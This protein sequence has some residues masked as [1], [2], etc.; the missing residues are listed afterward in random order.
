MEGPLYLEYISL[1]PEWSTDHRRRLVMVDDEDTGYSI[2]FGSKNGW[3]RLDFTF[4]GVNV[5]DVLENLD[6]DIDNL[7]NP[8]GTL[9]ISGAD[10]FVAFDGE[11]FFL[12]SSLPDQTNHT[13][14]E[15]LQT[16]GTKAYWYKLTAKD[17]LPGQT[18]QQ[19]KFLRT[20]GSRVKWSVVP[21]DLPPQGG[22]RGKILS[23]NGSSPSWSTIQDV[24]GLPEKNGH[25]GEFL[26][27]NEDEG[28]LLWESPLPD[29][30]TTEVRHLANDGNTTYWS[31]DIV[32]ATPSERATL[33]TDGGGNVK[34]SRYDIL[35][36]Q[37]Y[38][39]GNV[40][41]T[42]GVYPY[43]TDVQI[44]QTL[45]GLED[46]N[47]ELEPQNN[48][49]LRFNE[50]TSLWESTEFT[51]NYVKTDG[52]STPTQDN[53]WVIGDNENRF[54]KIYSVCFIGTASQTRMADL[55]ENYTCKDEPEIGRVMLISE[56]EDFDCEQSNETAS[57]RVLGVLSDSPGYLMNK[58]LEGISVGLKGRLPCY[59]KGPVKKGEP[60]VSHTYGRAIGVRSLDLDIP[61]GSIIGRSNQTIHT[62]ETKLIEVII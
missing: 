5:D 2:Y 44:E 37:E 59:V 25:G 57:D 26:K 8:D 49:I 21:S 13:N 31:P 4:S 10:V 39:D 17:I 35:P 47:D 46:V 40:L 23:T 52:D 61:N 28:S 53:Q 38:N 1:L 54:K 55:A 24:F 16:D 33:I 22:N 41:A 58:D 34:W 6:F 45:I 32:P 12:T 3:R 14:G 11:N 48:D 51:G 62:H 9:N 36:K 27:V 42:N 30:T 60:L 19:G 20:D 15:V 56:N 43:W 7:Y 50:S 29:N 18:G